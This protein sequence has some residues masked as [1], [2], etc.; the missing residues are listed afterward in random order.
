MN[1]LCKNTINKYICVLSP[2]KNCGFLVF[3]PADRKVPDYPIPTKRQIHPIYF[4]SIITRTFRL[5]Q[6]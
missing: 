5:P 3:F 4:K 1:G 2:K 6:L